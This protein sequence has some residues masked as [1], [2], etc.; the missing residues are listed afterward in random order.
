MPKP[1][2]AA[3]DLAQA[4]GSLKTGCHVVLI[5]GVPLTENLP[6]L[7]G[8]SQRFRTSLKQFAMAAIRKQIAADEIQR[9]VEAQIRKLQ[10]HGIN[11]DAP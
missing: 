6:S 7:A 9:E 2:N 3:I 1:R 5:D 11:L 10:S 8:N 4:L